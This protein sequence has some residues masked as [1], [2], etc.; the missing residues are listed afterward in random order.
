MSDNVRIK[1]EMINAYMH[2]CL[3]ALL[4]K[5]PNIPNFDLSI[6]KIN[7]QYDKAYEFLMKTESFDEIFIS[8]LNVMDELAHDIDLSSIGDNVYIKRENLKKY[9]EAEEVMLITLP[10]LKSSKK[11]K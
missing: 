2:L 3:A 9:L 5:D 11:N 6:D 10:N 7:N 1:S 4:K 8:C